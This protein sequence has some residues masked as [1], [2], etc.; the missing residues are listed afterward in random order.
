MYIDLEQYSLDW[1][2]TPVREKK[3]YKTKWQS[4]TARKAIAADLKNNR[5]DGVAL[6]LG[7]KSGI[8]AVDL[9][10][11]GAIGLWQQ[12]EQENGK[13]KTI[14]WTS[15]REGRKC[16]IFVI[17]SMFWG[18]VRSQNYKGENGDEIEI[19]WG[20]RNQTLPPSIHPE[21]KEP[22][23]WI[24]SPA[25]TE[26]ATAPNWL[27]EKMLV[28]EEKPQPLPAPSRPPVFQDG[29]VPI[30]IEVCLTKCDRD[31]LA[32]GVAEGGRNQAAFR[33]GVNAI[34]TER[35]LQ[36]LG[37]STANTAEQIYWDF[38]RLCGLD[39][40]KEE[41][42]EARAT[43]QSALKSCDGASLTEE[44]LINCANA[45]IYRESRQV[46]GGRSVLVQGRSGTNLVA[47][48]KKDELTFEET[49]KAVK[50]V[51]G[52]QLND[53]DELGRLI[54]IESR[55]G[56]SGSK[57]NAV[58]RACRSQ[59][60]SELL[61]EEIK[62]YRDETDPIKRMKLKSRICGQYQLSGWDLKQL[63]EETERKEK[64]PKKSVFTMSE[65]MAI[66]TKSI[67]YLVPGLLPNGEMVVL[68]ALAKVGKTLL[69]A[70]LAHAVVSGGEFMGERVRQGKVLV[71]CSDQSDRS[72]VIRLK[73]R[74]TS[75]IDGI[76]DR[77]RFMNYLD[78]G[79]L[80]EL[81]R[82]LS[83][84]RPDLVVIDSLTSIS[85]NS[86]VSEYD[87]AIVK[88]LIVMR[89]LI[90]SY[91]ASSILIHH[92]GKS[93]DHVGISKISGSAR[94]PSIAF[95]VW[96]LS[97]TVNKEGDIVGDSRFL[98]ITPRD[99]ERT[100]LSLSIK[101]R[102]EWL[103][104]MYEFEGEHGVDD[105]SKSL[106]D[107]VTAL[108]RTYS[109]KGLEFSEINQHL[110]AETSSLYKA[111]DRLEDRQVIGRRKSQVDRRKWVYYI[112]GSETDDVVQKSTDPVLKSPPPS[113]I[114]PENVQEYDQTHTQ[115]EIQELDIYS[116]D[117]RHPNWDEPPVEYLKPLPSNESRELLDTTP[118][119]R[120]GG[121][122]SGVDESINKEDV[123]LHPAPKSTQ[124]CN[125]RLAS[126]APSGGKPATGTGLCGVEMPEL[127]NKIIVMTED[128]DRLTTIIRMSE[129]GSSPFP[130]YH[131]PLGDFTFDQV[132]FPEPQE[133]GVK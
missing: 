124:N 19:R 77:F 45:Y 92:E 37:Y 98:K 83:E 129:S 46:V 62:R 85:Q 10:G 86:N 13:T 132:C 84:F 70:D 118:K 14:E 3:A 63:I 78:V 6:I 82:V 116:T 17:P 115:R 15:G 79:D 25:D 130:T 121:E 56:L 96:Q 89:D 12:W 5:A 87:P 108:L 23:Y 47:L 117:I 41:I 8:V 122:K 113:P 81:E 90:Q 53:I 20:N 93:R 88:P 111:L 33:I 48:P 109:P 68:A 50:E 125:D 114:Y 30:P 39:Q 106:G 51:L 103:T 24:N 127:D 61:E 34:A 16:L 75:D 49:V 110:N 100:T 102:G 99:G 72:T 65:L 29:V 126:A 9:D 128:G 69:A 73:L 21:T 44:A 52:Q 80:S 107:R 119:K 60:R 64:A 74:G 22:Y 101:P 133:G 105:E 38:C 28:E 57:F 131:T 97:G 58:V 112:G 4:G 67:D 95:S 36:R 42:R 43:W 120:G 35:E 32:R 40:K 71:I 91:G 1:P 18:Q 7:E 2:L 94:I 76:D 31:D 11:S 104:G 54:E 66:E 123:A 55:S 26:V 59:S 27:I